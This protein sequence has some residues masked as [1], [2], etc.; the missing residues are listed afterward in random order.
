MAILSA[1]K[2]AALAIAGVFLFFPS[3]L[4]SHFV[5]EPDIEGLVDP[6][7]IQAANMAF[8]SENWHWFGLMIVVSAIGSLALYVLFSPSFR[9]TVGFA[10]TKAAGLFMFFFIANIII[11]IAIFF[12]ALAFVVPAL[13]LIGRL[14]LVPIVIADQAERNPIAAIK[15]GWALTT[16]NGWS[17]FFLMLIIIVVGLI[18]LVV[19]GVMIGLVLT[20][21]SGGAGFPLAQII[22]NNLLAT[23]L[24]LVIMA[25]VASVYLELTG[26]SHPVPKSVE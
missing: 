2:E 25:V 1:H 26:A 9:G 23:G 24:Q 17:I 10:L 3:V 14:A 15:R 21:L 18:A 7:A 5:G 12:G 16:G 20:L 22:A 4:L 13:Y 6:A 19:A 8:F 11:G